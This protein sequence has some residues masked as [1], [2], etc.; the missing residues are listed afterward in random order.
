[1]VPPFKCSPRFIIEFRNRHKLSLRRPSIKRRPTTTDAQ[2]KAFIGKVKELMRDI[3][4]ERIV[5]IDETNWRTVAGGFKTWAVKGAE[6][7][8]CIV[9]NDDKQGVT[10]IAG[11]SAAGGKLPLTVIGK[12][13]TRRCLA[14]Y[15]LRS[16]VWGSIPN[17][18]GRRRIS[19]VLIFGT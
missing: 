6:S 10:V 12:G 13:K 1:V 15:H 3:P 14:G 16:E 8:H 5:N 11:I 7:A 17:P 18:G 9:A 4:A 2:V 19:R